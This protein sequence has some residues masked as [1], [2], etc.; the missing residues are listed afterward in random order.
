MKNIKV[1]K[2]KDIEKCSQIATDIFSEY[3]SS[4]LSKNLI[5]YM[6]DAFFDIYSMKE[7]INTNTTYFF[8]VVENQ[9]IG[10]LAYI[11]KPDHLYL[12]KINLYKEQRHR[13]YSKKV[14]AFI[15]DKALEFNKDKI[16]LNVNKNNQIAINSYEKSGFRKI[17]EVRIPIGEDYF[18]DDYVYQFII[19]K[20]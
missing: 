9:I 16:I 6:V 1:E 3:Y 12:S 5:D 19:E 7:S 8:I 2:E 17:D 15:K 18:M 4:I 14:F 13:G 10:Y 11:L 20:F